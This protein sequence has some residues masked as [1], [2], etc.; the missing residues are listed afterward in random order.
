M[1]MKVVNVEFVENE[2]VELDVAQI[3][4]NWGWGGDGCDY[5][6]DE[7]GDACGD[8][9][10]EKINFTAIPFNTK[11]TTL[12]IPNNQSKPIV[13]SLFPHLL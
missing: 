2:M 3:G 6:G 13:Q 4:L 12:F 1:E 11:L 7:C 8:S 5:D 9:N 10:A